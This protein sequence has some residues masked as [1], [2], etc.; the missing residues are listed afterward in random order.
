[1]VQQLQCCGAIRLHLLHSTTLAA[2]VTQPGTCLTRCTSTLL[3][4][5]S[6]QACS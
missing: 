2:V 4:L 3:L 5:L 6:P 1:V